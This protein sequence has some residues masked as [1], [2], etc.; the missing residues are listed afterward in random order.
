MIYINKV[1]YIL[2]NLNY[3]LWWKW[4]EIERKV[5]ENEEKNAKEEV[6]IASEM[7]VV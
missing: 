5:E 4:H 1:E 7:F 2:L 6:M 3:E